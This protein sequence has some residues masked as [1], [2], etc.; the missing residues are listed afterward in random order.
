MCRWDVKPGFTHDVTW[1]PHPLTC[2]VYQHIGY[3]NIFHAFSTLFKHNQILIVIR[4]RQLQEYFFIYRGISVLWSFFCLLQNSLSFRF[5]L[6]VYLPTHVNGYN[7][8]LM[9]SLLA[10]SPT[11]LITSTSIAFT[12]S[13]VYA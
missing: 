1:E 4:T 2:Y 7:P 12:K 8:S 6:E 13:L 9:V 10:E 11:A 3:M 5:R